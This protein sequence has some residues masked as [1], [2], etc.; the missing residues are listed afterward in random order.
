MPVNQAF[1]LDSAKVALAETCPMPMPDIMLSTSSTTLGS[2]R[3]HSC[4]KA[5]VEG[6][7]NRQRHRH[8]TQLIED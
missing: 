1:A 8:E 4:E 3:T 2:S 7:R 5:T 6:K